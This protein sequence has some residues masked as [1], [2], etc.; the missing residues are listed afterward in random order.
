MITNH[1]IPDSDIKYYLS[2]ADVVVQPYRSY[3]EWCH[4]IGFT[5]SKYQWSLQMWFITEI[6]PT[7]KSGIGL[8]SW[9]KFSCSM[10]S[11][12]FAYPQDYFFTTNSIE[13]TKLSWE[14]NSR[15]KNIESRDDI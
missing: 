9:C 15:Q 3:A 1:F 6:G 10:Y 2:A 4:T 11:R 12:L 5:I 8:Q 7:W 13:K 14:K